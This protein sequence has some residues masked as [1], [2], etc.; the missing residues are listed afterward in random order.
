MALANFDVVGDHMANLLIETDRK[1]MRIDFGG[2][3]QFG[4]TGKLKSSGFRASGIS[5]DISLFLH[6][7]KRHSAN[8]LR[9]EVATAI[10]S[11]PALCRI[12]DC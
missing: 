7:K 2:C 8:E 6:D 9:V 11:Q 10:R 3:L 12:A 5:N 4:P 1:V